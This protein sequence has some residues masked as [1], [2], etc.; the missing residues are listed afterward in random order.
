MRL[1]IFSA[2]YG[3]LEKIIETEIIK[4][5][6][7]GAIVCDNKKIELKDSIFP[8]ISKKNEYYNELSILYSVWKEYSKG[9]DYVGLC[10]YRRYFVTNF[11]KYYYE[12]M[13]RLGLKANSKEIV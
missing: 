13:K 8:E 5:V 6:Q 11:S 9:L 1:R 12:I 4:P 2:Y 7:G 10:H 3:N